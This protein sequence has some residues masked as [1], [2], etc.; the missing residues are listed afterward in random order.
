MTVQQEMKEPH[1]RIGVTAFVITIAALLGII[2]FFIYQYFSLSSEFTVDSIIAA[3][4]STIIVGFFF[5]LALCVG[6]IMGI[7][8]LF[9]KNTNK[10]FGILSLAATA[11]NILILI[12]GIIIYSITGAVF[13]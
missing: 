2:I 6:M 12:A 8:S 1:G 4:F 11:I 3:V 10:L 7:V 9:Q 13:H 5:V